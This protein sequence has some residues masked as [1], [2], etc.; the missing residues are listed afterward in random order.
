MKF[1]SDLFRKAAA[2]LKVAA[3]GERSELDELQL[4]ISMHRSR[5]N[6]LEAE[7]TAVRNQ[8][9]EVNRLASELVVSFSEGSPSSGS[10]LDGLENKKRAIERRLEGLTLR[11]ASL[12]SELAPQERRC[13][14][15]AKVRDIE[16]RE[17]ALRETRARCHDLVD[18]VLSDWR[19]ACE[20]SFE[21]FATLHSGMHAS[22]GSG[23]EQ[24]TETE[25]YRQAFRL[26][27]AE[28]MEKILRASLEPINQNWTRLRTD[29]VHHLEVMPGA[30]KK[31]VMRAAG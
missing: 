16:S 28:I 24:Q 11:I 9:A 22:L 30:P 18:S 2:P 7:E 19:S 23:P 6:A 29:L 25:A 1:I 17:K 20:K 3:N 12:R 13:S 31:E 21:L 10:A 27:N 14:D 26:L 4:A 5:L 8:L 15:L